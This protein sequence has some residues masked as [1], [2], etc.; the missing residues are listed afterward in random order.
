MLLWD[1]KSHVDGTE[2][3]DH[4]QRRAV[5]DPHQ[6]PLV[7][8]QASYLAVDRRVEVAVGQLNFDVFHR[9]LVRV[10]HRLQRVGIGP[11]LVILLLGN[12]L[13]LQQIRVTARLFARVLQL[14]H[15][16]RQVR[17]GLFHRGF[18]GTRIDGEEHLSFLDVL[19]FLE[20]GLREHAGNLTLDGD[21]G[22][23][24]AVAD[25]TNLDGY[26][27]L[28]GRYYQHRHGLAAAAAAT[29]LAALTGRA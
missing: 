15:V 12:V 16:P 9:R 21:G 29:A 19:P 5:V 1:G 8:Q 25:R 17:F 18:E 10:D 27:L 13:F 23:R 28:L 11:D 20:V 3:I 2:L 22:K 6:V 14:R 4:H 24:L 26:G 7:H